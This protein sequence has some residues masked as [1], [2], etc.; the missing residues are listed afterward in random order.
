[1][2]LKEACEKLGI[3]YE[4]NLSRFAKNE[5][6][7]IRFLKKLLLDDNYINLKDSI[8]KKDYLKVENYAHILKGI[9][10]NLGLDK[11]YIASSNLVQCVRNKQYNDIQQYYNILSSEYLYSESVIKNLE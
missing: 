10:A 3:D 11:L 9:F 7:Y 8:D 6:L 4:K 5:D 2:K 1:M